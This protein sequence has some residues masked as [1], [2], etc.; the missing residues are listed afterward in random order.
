MIIAILKSRYL[1][2][3]TIFFDSVKSFG[4]PMTYS[5]QKDN[6]TFLDLRP[7]TPLIDLYIL[8]NWQV[9]FSEISYTSTML[10]VLCSSVVQHVPTWPQMSLPCIDSLQ[11]QL[12]TVRVV[13]EACQPP[14]TERGCVLFYRLETVRQKVTIFVKACK[15]YR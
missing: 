9:G 1:R 5:I 6:K 7:P 3:G 2:L 12:V 11:D 13:M 10:L 14:D 15:A 4:L 8:C